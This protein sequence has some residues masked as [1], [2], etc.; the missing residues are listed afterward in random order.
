MQQVKIIKSQ[1]AFDLQ[2]DINK[3]LVSINNE[4]FKVVDI[5]FSVGA[6]DYGVCYYAMI[7]YED[8]DSRSMEL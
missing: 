6:Y 4:G 3:K 7:I 1:Y 2:S 8:S 5:K